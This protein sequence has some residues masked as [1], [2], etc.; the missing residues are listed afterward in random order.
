M[1]LKTTDGRCR[2]G[3]TWKLKYQKYWPEGPLTVLI[4]MIDG[5]QWCLIE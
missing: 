5:I 4:K 2:R 1:L 3:F